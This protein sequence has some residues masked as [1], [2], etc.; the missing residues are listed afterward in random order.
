[1][2]RM[3]VGALGPPAVHVHLIGDEG[4][5]SGAGNGRHGLLA[6]PPR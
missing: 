5:V 2:T 4:P 6:H 1:M 3:K